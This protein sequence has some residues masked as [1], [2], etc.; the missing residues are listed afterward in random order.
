MNTHYFLS[1]YILLTF[2]SINFV[3]TISVFISIDISKRLP[4]YYISSNVLQSAKL[5]F[6]I[7]CPEKIAQKI[8]QIYYIYPKLFFKK[9][10]CICM[11]LRILVNFFL[12]LYITLHI[13]SFQRSRGQFF[14]NEIYKKN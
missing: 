6:A 14:T 2:T 3:C 8:S 11:I 5:K 1:I 10:V 13:F 12:L 7:F 9:S 4:S